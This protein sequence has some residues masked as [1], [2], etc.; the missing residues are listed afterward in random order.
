MRLAFAQCPRASR[1]RGSAQS[2]FRKPRFTARWRS[3]PMAAVLRDLSAE[4]L[5][6]LQ[7]S[8]NL[9]PALYAHPSWVEPHEV[10]PGTPFWTRCISTALLRAL[11]LEEQFDCDFSDPAMRLALVDAAA[12][13]RFGGF[14]GAVLMRDRLRHI[15]QHSA[16]DAVRRAMGAGPHRFALRWR[17]NA[18]EAASEP[19]IGWPA[20]DGVL[21]SEQMWAQHS[22]RLVMACVPPSAAGTLERL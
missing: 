13:L 11:G 14:A 19:H 7:V 15:V 1:A 10:T 20:A 17:A 8:F 21:A 22:A 16:V 9:H 4:R 5:F 3:P 12:L 6:D 18:S 2:R